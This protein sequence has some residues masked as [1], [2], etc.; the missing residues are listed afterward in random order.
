MSAIPAGG[1]YCCAQRQ[2]IGQSRHHNSSTA[3]GKRIQNGATTLGCK[4]RDDKRG[5]MDTASWQVCFKDDSQAA[6]THKDR[7]TG[8]RTVA[9]GKA[10]T[11]GLRKTRRLQDTRNCF[12]CWPFPVTAHGEY[13]YSLPKGSFTGRLKRPDLQHCHSPCIEALWPC[14]YA[15]ALGVHRLGVATPSGCFVLQIFQHGV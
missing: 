14:P 11:M 3:R 13:Q 2:I 10:A 7:I 12:S 15:E 4:Q 1:T 8:T 5:K 6:K 9:D